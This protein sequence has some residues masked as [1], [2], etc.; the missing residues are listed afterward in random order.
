MRALEQS[1]GFATLNEIYRHAVSAPGVSWGTKTPHASVRRILQTHP[2]LFFRI[3]PGL[4]GLKSR[5]QQI[6]EQLGIGEKATDKQKQQFDH[7]YYQGLLV[8]I[9]NMMGFSTYIPSQDKNKIFLSR[10]LGD[11]AT[12]NKLPLFT[13]KELVH[14]A[15]RIDVVWINERGFPEAFFEVEHTTNFRDALVKFGE[16][17]DFSTRFRIVADESR[18]S[19]FEKTVKLQSFKAVQKRVRFI[20]YDKVGELHSQWSKAK[21]MLNI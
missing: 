4:W 10:K 21:T 20:S 17:I 1:G 19:Q 7:S 9:G 8:E 14:T 13:Y 16:F 3:K 6:L 12:L 15:G 18:R 5:E 11:I 2:S